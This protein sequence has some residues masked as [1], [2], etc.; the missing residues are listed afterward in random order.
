MIGFRIEGGARLK[1]TVEVSRA[2]NAILPIMAASIMSDGIVIIEDVPDLRDVETMSAILDVLGV[3]VER[4]EDGS[5]SIDPSGL[6]NPF[7]P[8]ELVS[9]MRASF[10]LLGPLVAKKGW[11]KVSFPGGCAIGP[12]PVDLHLKGLSALGCSIRIEHGYVIAEAEK[13]KGTRIDLLGPN[14]PS[15]GATEN[16]MMA[17]TLADGVTVIDNA[18]KEPE[19]VDLANFLSSMGAKIQGAGTS[20]I[21]I[22]GVDGLDGTRYR[23]IPDRIEAGTLTV[24][25][26][27]TDGEVEIRGVKPDHMKTELEKLQEIGAKVEIG[28][29]SIRVFGKGDLKGCDIRTAPY[30]GFATDLQAQFMALLSTASGVSTITET[31][32]ENRFMHALELRRMGADITIDGRTAIVRGVERLS[33]AQVMASDLRAGVSLVIAGLIAEGTTYVSRIY[34]I[35]RGF[36]KIDK[37]LLSLGAR[38]WREEIG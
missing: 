1:G 33:G 9:T 11:A 21:V 31:I 4:K 15:V 35:D 29:G 22:E 2:K 16:V 24:A 36:D 37:K 6:N 26:V 23:T 17:A 8:Y 32:F 28:E 38:I 7:A 12:R 30:P 27:A 25:A 34:H 5:I 18:A 20:T 19:V 13:L 10:F 3:G 14:G